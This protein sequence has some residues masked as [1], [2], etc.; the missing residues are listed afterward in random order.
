MID[1][2]GVNQAAAWKS[3]ATYTMLRLLKTGDLDSSDAAF[4]RQ[5]LVAGGSEDDAASFLSL[6]R[7]HR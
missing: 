3:V 4:I 6:Y 5:Q 2:S 7:E 1:R